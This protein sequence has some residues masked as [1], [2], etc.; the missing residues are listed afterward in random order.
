MN[1]KE[2]IIVDGRKVILQKSISNEKLRNQVKYVIYCSNLNFKTKKE[3]LED[4]LINEGK[5]EKNNILKI[6]ICKDENDKPKGYGFIEFINKE[7]MDKAIQLNGKI[8]KGRNIIINESKRNITVKKKINEEKINNNQMLKKKISIN[9]DND[10]ENTIV[11]KQKVTNKD[12]KK[13]FDF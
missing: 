4:F 7:D 2:D 9:D 13:L 8:L 10:E 5:I 6:L 3:H 11:K 1:N 12:F